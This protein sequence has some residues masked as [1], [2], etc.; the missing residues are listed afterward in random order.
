MRKREK[1]ACRTK[2]KSKRLHIPIK[3]VIFAND[4]SSATTD[5]GVPPK[6]VG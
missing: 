2:E 5:G 1:T 6:W 4:K 3:R